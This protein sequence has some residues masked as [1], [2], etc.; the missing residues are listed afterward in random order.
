MLTVKIPSISGNAVSVQLVIGDL[1]LDLPTSQRIIQ[2]DLP[3]DGTMITLLGVDSSG[4]AFHALSRELKEPYSFEPNTLNFEV[5][6]ET[7]VK[8]YEPLKHV[9]RQQ[10]REI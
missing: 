2:T 4:N 1:V 10:V 7:I 5:K 3:K 9:N 6:R 8:K